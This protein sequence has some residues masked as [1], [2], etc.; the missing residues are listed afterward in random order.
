MRALLVIA[1]L[2]ACSRESPQPNQPPQATPA[3]QAPAPVAAVAAATTARVEVAPEPAKPEELPAP[4]RALTDGEIAILKPI[5]RDGIDYAKV[6][7]IDAKYPFQPNN[8]YMTPRGHVYA[9]GSLYRADFS[10]AGTA[11]RGVFVHE[12]AHVWQHENG[13]DLV[14][15]GV[16]EFAKYRGDYE[17][18]YPYTLVAGR[19]LV[20]FGI[21]QQAS[22]VQDYFLI[23]V[24]HATPERIQNRVS[25]DELAPLYASTLAKFLG[26]ARYAR[27][28]DPKELV[29]CHAAAAAAEPPGAAG[30]KE[31]PAEHAAAHMCAWRFETPKH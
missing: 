30:C 19:D 2:A 15:A 28:V 22:I 21:E 31:K 13:L 27:S 8:V 26:D 25:R 20:E 14:A 9:P 5:F 3:A 16:A 18:A 17:K 29:D 10:K 4:N 6:R 7:V 1:T 24:E 12:L 23:S 11:Y